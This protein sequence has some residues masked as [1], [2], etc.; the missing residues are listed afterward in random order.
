VSDEF[1]IR[2]VR[3]G[4]GN[5]VAHSWVEFGQYYASRDPARFRVPEMEGLA[6]WFNSRID[7]AHDL[8]LV[9]ERA[10]KIV[11]FLEARLWPAPDDAARQL[12]KELSEPSLS[13]TTLFVTERERGHGVGR[14]LM[15]AAEDRGRGS[16]ATSA[17]VIAIADSPLAV[18]FYAEMEY[19]QNTIGFWKP[20]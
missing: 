3:P 5:A 9:A 10:G 17:A 14:S 19:R 20:I 4:D 18:P 16:G 11:G 2:S 15:Q 8:W 1:N 7:A 12:M 13:V 6:E